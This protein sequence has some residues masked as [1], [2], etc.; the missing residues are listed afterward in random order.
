METFG[1]PNT[2]SAASFGSSLTTTDISNF[3]TRLNTFLSSLSPALQA[4]AA[5][6]PTTTLSADAT[7][8][9]GA[10]GTLWD[11]AALLVPEALLA[12]AANMLQQAA[13]AANVAAALSATAQIRLPILASAAP[14]TTLSSNEQMRMAVAANPAPAAAIIVKESMLLK[15]NST[16]APAASLGANLTI[17]SAG[18]TAWDGSAL[19]VPAAVMAA[20]ARQVMQIGAAM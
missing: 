11:G 19:F 12:S 3:Y 14:T 20:N 4:A 8:V 5:L 9:T 16:L 1:G 18:A 2:L 15:S 6:A 7:L 17:P 10:A 13:A